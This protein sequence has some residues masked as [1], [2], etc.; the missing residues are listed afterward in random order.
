M[1]QDLAHAFWDRKLKFD[2]V[3]NCELIEVKCAMGILQLFPELP[4]SLTY[5]I[6]YILLLI[7]FHLFQCFHLFYCSSP[8]LS[9]ILA[10]S[11][12]FWKICFQDTRE[13]TPNLIFN[14]VDILYFPGVRKSSD[15]SLLTLPSDL[16]VSLL[17]SWYLV[18]TTVL[19]F[20]KLRL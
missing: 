14:I 2:F 19:V 11:N 3:T 13:N 9:F 10:H 18:D 20:L 5:S 17:L 4:Y 8:I 1:F 16:D 15:K 7:F 6:A 12:F